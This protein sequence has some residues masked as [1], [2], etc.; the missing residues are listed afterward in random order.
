MYASKR[1]NIV[2]AST[3]NYEL[4]DYYDVWGN[5]ED[6][7]DVNDISRTGEILT[8]DDDASDRDIIDGLVRIGYLKP[9]AAS[10]VIIE[11]NDP[12]F[13]EI[14]EEDTYMPLG[15]LEEVS[16]NA[17]RRIRGKSIR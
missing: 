7:F 15:R 12:S 16:V 5:P 4:V 3:R 9:S 10:K 8:I 13:I 11:A 6:G 17:S 1:K 14:F 2:T